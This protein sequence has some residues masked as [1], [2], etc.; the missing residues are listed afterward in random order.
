M[1]KTF[2]S[3]F[4]SQVHELVAVPSF[5][6]SL[7]LLSAAVR[8]NPKFHSFSEISKVYDGLSVTEQKSFRDFLFSS[9]HFT[10]YSLFQFLE[11]YGEQD[12]STENLSI[13]IVV[14]D[15]GSSGN[16]IELFSE[17]DRTFRTQFR[18]FLATSSWQELLA[19]LNTD[20]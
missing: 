6:T 4:I 1:D 9:V 7:G 2:V 8:G 18:R 15:T 17:T 10:C 20:I 3:D 14:T 12:E 5:T 16:K 13:D 11:E 19:R